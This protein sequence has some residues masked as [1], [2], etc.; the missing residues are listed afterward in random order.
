[1]RTLLAGILAVTLITGTPAMAGGG[2][3]KDA[4][5]AEATH[6]TPAA[7]KPAELAKSGA[8]AT[9]LETELGQLRGMLEAQ[10]RQLAEQKKKIEALETERKAIPTNST[11]A[12]AGSPTTT[13]T[14]PAVPGGT[15]AALEA[16]DK[17]VEAIPETSGKNPRTMEVQSGWNGDHFFLKSSDGSFSI[18]PYGYWQVDSRAYHGASAPAGTF[19]I[20]RGRLGFQGT[21]GKHYEFAFLADFADTHSTIVRDFYLNVKPIPEIQFQFGQF[22]EPFA[23]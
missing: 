20:R 2:E 10:A 11:P 13:P 22:K 3:G 23:Q 21:L 1:M 14:L 5:A 9:S 17:S 15:H 19:A 8:S 7:G 16:E 12:P 18:Q 4:V 6:V